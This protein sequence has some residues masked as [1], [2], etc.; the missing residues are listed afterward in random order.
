MVQRMG[1]NR[2]LF[3]EAFLFCFKMSFPD[4]VNSLR[5]KDA[6]ALLE[7]SD[8]SI[9]DISHQ[10]GFGTIRTFRWQFQAKYNIT[11]KDYRKSAGKK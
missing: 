1:T 7:Q 8:P 3:I 6:V 4:Y 5:L 9:E 2:E 10:T 11:P